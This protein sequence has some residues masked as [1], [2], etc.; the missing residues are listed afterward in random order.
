MKPFLK[1]AGSKYKIIEKIRSSLP[2]GSRLVEPFAGSG[3]VFL[4]VEYEKYFIADVNPDVINLF[5]ILKDEGERF[6]N[7]A[8]GFFAEN[9]NSKDVYYSFREEFNLTD[10]TRRKAAIFVYLNRHCFNGLCRYNSKGKFNVPFGKYTKPLFPKKEMFYFHKKILSSVEFKVSDFK[11]TMSNAK[12]GDV[13]YCDP[14]YAPL[15]ETANFSDY[16]K[17]GFTLK[18]QED[19]A[20]MAFSLKQKGIPVIISNHDTPFTRELYNSAKI[21]AFDVQRFISS[22]GGSR[23]KAHE[24]IAIFS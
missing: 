1:W 10:D 19:L 24:L 4:N 14:P 11:E 9:N 15:S 21:E 12:F 2:A 18:D 5:S 8:E 23:N 22:K 16:T 3:S 13:I 6:I 20:E 17:N 7:Y